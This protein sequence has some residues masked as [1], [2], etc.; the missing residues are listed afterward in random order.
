MTICYSVM[1]CW[2]QMTQWLNGDLMYKLRILAFK[3]SILVELWNGMIMLLKRHSIQGPY[4]RL[5]SEVSKY[6]LR[7]TET[8]VTELP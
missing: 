2:P 7:V 1:F 8:I 6:D 5:P 4:N 3:I